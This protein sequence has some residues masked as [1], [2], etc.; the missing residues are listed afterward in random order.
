MGQHDTEMERPEI[1]GS[2]CPSLLDWWGN[3]L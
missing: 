2:N 3:L 1:V